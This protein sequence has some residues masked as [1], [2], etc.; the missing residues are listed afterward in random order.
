MFW[1]VLSIRHSHYAY[2]HIN[3]MVWEYYIGHG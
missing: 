2:T 1:L 3:N